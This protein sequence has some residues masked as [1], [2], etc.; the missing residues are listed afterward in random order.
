MKKGF[1]RSD[2]FAGLAVSLLVVFLG[3]IGSFDNLERAAYDY[4]VRSSTKAPSSK[5]AVIAIDDVSIANMGRWPWPRDIHAEMH[6]ILKNGGAK[7]IGQT[8]FFIDPQVDPGLKHIQNLLNLYGTS[9]LSTDLSP[10]RKKFPVQVANLEADLGLL[11][12]EL[13]KAETELN[14]DR[15]LADSL[16][17]AENVVLAMHLAIGHPL[18]RPDTRLPD[19]VKRNLLKNVSNNPATNPDGFTPLPSVDALFPI[20]EVG[21]AADSIGVLIA[22][23]DSDGGIRSEPLVIDFFDEYYPSLSLI[24]AARS[25]NLGP[26]DIK[27]NL[28]EG[29]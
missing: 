9:S 17:A 27:V 20:D 12:E 1:L 10:L 7:I 13:L 23:P 8:T 18:G 24:L 6:R 26:D 2:W 11:G 5:V 16:L 22:Y 4:G 28:G 15:I 21:P 14:T 29:I 25:L 19:Y 3:F